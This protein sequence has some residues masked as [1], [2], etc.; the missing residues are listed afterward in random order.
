MLKIKDFF[1]ETTGISSTLKPP[2]KGRAEPSRTPNAGEA[3]AEDVTA[4]KS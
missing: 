4:K 2:G 1:G 3:Q